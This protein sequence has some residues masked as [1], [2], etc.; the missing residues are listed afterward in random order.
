MPPRWGLVF[1]EHAA[2]YKHVAPLA[3]GN[4]PDSTVIETLAG[5]ATNDRGISVFPS[6]ADKSTL[7][8]R[9]EFG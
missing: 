4:S 9:F 5:L 7:L 8:K 6:C 1:V 2:C 3:L